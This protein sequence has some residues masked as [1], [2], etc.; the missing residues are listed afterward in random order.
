MV[1]VLQIKTLLGIESSDT[2]KDIL[3]NTIIDMCADEAVT[4]CRLSEYEDKLDGAVIKMVIQ[5][6]NRLGSEGIASQS[7][8]GVNESY[9]EGY[10]LDIIK[11]LNRFKRIV[12]I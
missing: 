8:S 1:E 12:L 3:L 10:T 2:S 9:V 4:Y 5:S 11:M 7:F 6:Y